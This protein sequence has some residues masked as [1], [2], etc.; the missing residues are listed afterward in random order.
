M[1][2]EIRLTRTFPFLTSRKGIAE[3]TGFS[4][5]TFYFHSFFSARENRCEPSQKKRKKE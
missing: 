1:A 4:T 5:G 3:P 2:N